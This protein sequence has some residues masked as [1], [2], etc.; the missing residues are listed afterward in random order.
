MESA[1][2]LLE[3]KTFSS[4]ELTDRCGEKGMIQTLKM[5]PVSLVCEFLVYQNLWSL[6]KKSK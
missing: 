6:F 1:K 2:A 4:E 3:G 5:W